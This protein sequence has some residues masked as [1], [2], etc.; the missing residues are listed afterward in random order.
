MDI[1]RECG[2]KA[3]TYHSGEL[4]IATMCAGLAVATETR[5]LGQVEAEDILEPIHGV[6]GATS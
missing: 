2:V 5:D 1:E 3:G 4:G 6:S